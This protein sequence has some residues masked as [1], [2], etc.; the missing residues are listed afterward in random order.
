MGYVRQRRGPLGSD[1]RCLLSAGEQWNHLTIQV[2]RT[3][4]N[5]LLYQ[6]ITL[7]GSAAKLNKTS[8]P[9]SAPG[10]WGVTVNYQMDGNYEQ[11][12]YTVYL[13][14]LTFTY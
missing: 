6:S 4:S 10:W 9:Y 14:K 7:N 3:S 1:R 8:A 5:Q 2:Q 11:Q 12:A 13:D